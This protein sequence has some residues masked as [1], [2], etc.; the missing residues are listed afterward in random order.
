MSH[1]ELTE[2]DLVALSRVLSKVLRHEPELVGVQLDAQGWV[3]VQELVDALRR[4]ARGLGAPKRLRTLP[5]VTRDA[6]RTVVE[7]NAKQ[8]FALSPDGER[9]RAVQGHSIDVDLGYTP[10]PPP[11]VLFHGTAF[12]SWPSIAKEGLHR[13]G[14][15]AVHLSP[16]VQTARAVGARHGKPV[17]L[18]VAAANMHR[19][20]FVFTEAENGTWLVES[21]PTEYLRMVK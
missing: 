2:A 4:K 21:V 20:G 16:D 12:A 5:E 10:K 11:P 3:P 9:I 19:N 17:V 7:S 15:H 13:G 1:P 6:I 14:R 18:E 8:R